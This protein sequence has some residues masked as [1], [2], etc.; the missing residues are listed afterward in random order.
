M[1]LASLK[2]AVS[3]AYSGQ[4]FALRLSELPAE[5]RSDALDALSRDSFPQQ[6]LRVSAAQPL[7]DAPPGDK[8]VVRGVGVDRPFAGMPVEIQFYLTGTA[9]T[10]RLL[11]HPGQSW[12]L[13]ES[14][15]DLSR[16]VIAAFVYSTSRPPSFVLRSHEEGQEKAGL[17]L[18][19]TLDL[20]RMTAG[21]SA[22]LGRA[23][24]TVSGRL[25]MGDG[26]AALLGIALDAEV[27]RNVNLLIATVDRLTFRIGSHLIYDFT[28]RISS[29][30]PFVALEAEIPFGAQN[31]VLKLGASVADF[32]GALRFEAHITERIDADFSDLAALSNGAALKA[33]LPSGFEV[34][35]VLAL[36]A[37]WLDWDLTAGKVAAVSLTAGSVKPWKILHL[38]ASNKDLVAENITL[39][40]LVREPFADHRPPVFA[41]VAGELSM[42]AEGRLL[43]SASYPAFEVRGG[44]K[45]GTILKLSEIVAEVYGKA[46]DIPS[47]E[48]TAFSCRMAPGQFA[49]A[50]ELFGEWQIGNLPLVLLEL[51]FTLDHGADN[52]S[53]EVGG[54]LE[55]GG[56]DVLVSASH[57]GNRKGWRFHGETAARQPIPIGKVIADIAKAFGV[58]QKLP[59]A[60]TGAT[61]HSLGIS[62]DTA[63][64]A[65][66]FTAATSIEVAPDK[67][68]DISLIVDVDPSATGYRKTVRGR[69]ELGGRTL[70][71][72]FD[73]REGENRFIAAYHEESTALVNLG[74]LVSAVSGHAGLIAAGRPYSF[75]VKD[76]LFA[77]ERTGV[78][79]ARF[80]LGADIGGGIDLSGL[81]LVGRALSESQALRL[82]FQPFFA[83]EDFGKDALDRVRA[84]MPPGGLALPEKTLA[85]NFSLSTSLQMGLTSMDLSLKLPATPAPPGNPGLATPP[86]AA[87][88]LWIDVQRE[89]G[90]V[91]FERVGIR[92][93]PDGLTFLLD[94]SIQAAGL[95][96]TLSGLSATVD[97]RALAEGR[98]KPKFELLGVGIDYRGGNAVQVS[99]SL[100]RKSVGGVNYEGAVTLKSGM[101]SLT[102]LGSYQEIDGHPSLFVGAILDYPI[103]GPCFFFVTGLVAAF[104]YN[105]ALLLPPIEELA[106]FPLIADRSEAP[107]LARMAPHLRAERGAVFLGF[108][109]SFNTFKAVKST[110]LVTASFGQ[111]FELNLIGRSTLRAPPRPDG[112]PRPLLSSAEMAWRASYYPDDGTLEVRAQLTPASYVLSPDCHISGGFAACAWFSGEHA[113]DFVMTLGG[114]HPEFQKP[115]HYPTVPRLALRWQV[116]PSALDP[117][118]PNFL[119]KGEAYFALTGSALMAGGLL[120]AA[121]Q[122]EHLSASFKASIDFLVAF[123]P[124]HYDARAHLQV[125]VA[126]S[127]WFFGTHTITAEV[128]ADLHVWGPPFAGTARVDLHI[129]SVDLTFGPQNP[130]EPLPLSWEDFKSVSLP[131]ENKLCTVAITGG[132]VR[133]SGGKWVVNPNELAL[134]TDSAVPSKKGSIGGTERALTSNTAFG[135]APMALAAADLS[136]RHSVTIKRNSIGNSIAVEADFRVTPLKKRYPSGLWG[137]SMIPRLTDEPFIENALAGFSITPVERALDVSARVTFRLDEANAGA[138]VLQLY[139]HHRPLL[140]A[141]DYIIEVRQDVVIRGTS[142]PIPA[143]TK[144]FV[145]AGERLALPPSRVY[146]L[147]PPDG[148]LG[149]APA[150]LPHV[151]LTPSTW[152]WERRA[153]STNDAPWLA[154]LLFDE[155]EAPKPHVVRV[156]ALHEAGV[157]FPV[158]EP[159]IGESVEKVTVIDVPWKTLREIVPTLTELSLL[160]HVR[161]SANDKG[162]P[163]GPPRAVVVGNRCPKGGARSIVHLVSVEGRYTNQAFDAQGAGGEDKIRLVSLL[164]WS[165]SCLA[166][167]P[168]FRATL[169]ALA[170]DAVSPW[171]F[172]VQ[173]PHS[174]R[175]GSEKMSQYR[176]PLLARQPGPGA[177]DPHYALSYEVAAE[178]GRLLAV[179][180][181]EISTALL[182]SQKARA[183]NL[184]REEQRRL[185]QY[186]HLY[187]GSGGPPELPALPDVVDA[188][189]RDLM[190]LKG[191][192]LR[193]LVP[194]EKLLPRESIRFFWVDPMWLDRMANGALTLGHSPQRARFSA[195]TGKP[196]RTGALV[197]SSVVAEWPDLVVKAPDRKGGPRKLQTGNIT[198]QRIANDVLLVLSDVE[199][200]ALDIRMGPQALHFGAD[201]SVR[202]RIP[203]TRVVDVASM[204]EGLADTSARIAVKMLG[205]PSPVMLRWVPAPPPRRG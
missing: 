45:P 124:Y 62:F 27:S 135:I 172:L 43:L 178:L 14:F 171:S 33:A 203:A 50:S 78:A 102:A 128:S 52:T 167:K 131:P 157:K 175:D 1:S 154:L 19:A 74:D 150:V 170:L 174:L 11:A 99:G 116:S 25:T 55:I 145:V 91:H 183:Q 151:I 29:P 163:I 94:A 201:A 144:T 3:A 147:F 54:L 130:H 103:G 61:I 117:T 24:Q 53:L 81:P 58:D 185:P 15:P 49:I 68:L 100:V 166:D 127:F 8:V 22:L 75:Q 18:A 186:A 97:A 205:R 137:Q 197:R 51:R 138:D 40:F 190:W 7:L 87:E 12:T 16:T 95:T 161:Q 41:S 98:L 104:G 44:L 83:S 66:M 38:E 9:A 23:E 80:V 188:W 162:E 112:D 101:L 121:W 93:G 179:Q 34:E 77:W 180:S 56:I 158:V 164:S 153:D 169:S 168:D 64:L 2:S 31:K 122:S 67:R 110:A 47:L 63:T 126:Y 89:L 36:K 198:V 113:G 192:P 106:Q 195:F 35:N 149:E 92:G 136:S 146:A 17:A 86:A 72:V 125:A 202:R 13:P 60:V 46:E 10:L 79:P 65:F 105:R 184:K 90:P 189:L 42:G 193:Y 165:F 6:T 118:G 129:F 194:D 73:A 88:G 141:G 48:V 155:S 111:R 152:P 39:S 76:T 142:K 132:L 20:A 176:G 82:R 84:L 85:K 114:Y 119:F 191:I 160:T 109:V 148:S 4:A 187:P 70:N 139:P 177:R 134:V 140:P 200:V 196:P 156:D 120:E 69:C 133:S 182:Q 37:F 123:Q 71:I 21:L 143:V 115:A 5:L 57:P 181:L 173:L 107:K 108:G 26:G 32:R 159:E 96:L 28:E 59:A 30:V 199:M 204:R